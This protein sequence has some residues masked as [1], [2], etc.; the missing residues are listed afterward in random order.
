[1]SD[2]SLP[3]ARLGTEGLEV[4]RR[5]ARNAFAVTE[6]DRMGLSLGRFGEVELVIEFVG[7]L[8]I[9]V[10]KLFKRCPSGQKQILVRG[11]GLALRFAFPERKAPEFEHDEGSG[12][13]GRVPKATPAMAGNNTP[14]SFPGVVASLLRNGSGGHHPDPLVQSSKASIGRQGP[15]PHLKAAETR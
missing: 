10:R 15:L 6:S 7:A 2:K 11:L 12:Y 9:E 3:A 14:Q 5:A 4:N 1:M 8:R 13:T